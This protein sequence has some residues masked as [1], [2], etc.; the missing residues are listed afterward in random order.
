MCGCV[1]GIGTKYGIR[2]GGGGVE[3][4]SGRVGLD[5][6]VNFTSLLGMTLFYL[7]DL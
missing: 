4:W 2:E 3:G 6:D 1:D 5:F 7:F